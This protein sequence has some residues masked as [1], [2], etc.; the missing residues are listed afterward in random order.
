MS[1]SSRIIL[2]IGA[3]G[4]FGGLVVAELARRGATVRALLRNAAILHPATYF[5]NLAPA[6]PGIVATGVLTEAFSV[7]AQVARVDYRDVAEV[8]A[9][10][11]T[12]DRLAGG[13]FELCAERLSPQDIA[14]IISDVTGRQIEVA[15]IAFQDWVR[16]AR[17]S[18]D[19]RQLERAEIVSGAPLFLIFQR[20]MHARIS[21]LPGAGPAAPCCRRHCFGRGNLSSA[22]ANLPLRV[23]RQRREQGDQQAG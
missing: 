8:A 15:E 13:S 7:A 16:L 9:E 23:E 3:H 14:M 1:S 18:Y 21:P 20:D 2:V 19:A 17:P 11:L 5:Q 4:Q 10:A 12:D 6:W 22:P